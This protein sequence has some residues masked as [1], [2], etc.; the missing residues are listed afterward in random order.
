MIFTSDMK[1]FIA[2]LEK[3]DVAY[4]VIGGFAV[5]YYGYVRTTQ[6]FDLLLSPSRENAQKMM[7]V[8]KEFGFGEAGISQEIMEVEGTAIH[9]GVE[10]NRI[11]VLTRIR[12]ASNKDIFSR[13]KRIRYL[14]VSMNIISMRDLLSSKRISKR[15]KDKADADELRKIAHKSRS[16]TA[17]EEK[18]KH[19]KRKK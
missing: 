11:D 12:G 7:K 10:P 19:R 18:T 5:N 2:L 1:D 6:D 8:L 4:L 3:H 16:P 17:P 14:G 9:L 13:K 15:P